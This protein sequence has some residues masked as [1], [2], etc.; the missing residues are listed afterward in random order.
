MRNGR[1]RRRN[2]RGR[3]IRSR[4]ERRNRRG[5]AVR[6]RRVRTYLHLLRT[7]EIR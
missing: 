3:T 7:K 6:S 4:G 5:R 1:E 2:R